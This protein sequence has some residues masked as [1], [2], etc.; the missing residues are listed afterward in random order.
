MYKEV[1]RPRKDKAKNWTKDVQRGRQTKKGQG[2]ELD[3]G[4][5]KR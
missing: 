5:T 1:G 3:K 4:C 2:K